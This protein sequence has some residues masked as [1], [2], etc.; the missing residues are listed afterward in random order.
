MRDALAVGL[1]QGIRDLNG[2]AQ[3]LIE[4]QRTLG[5]PLGQRF[6]LQVLHDQEV[7]T[8]LLAD[9]VEGADVRVAQRGNCPGLTLEPLF[10]IRMSGDM[11]GQ[12][13]D[14][15]G[16]VQA[17]VSGFVDFAHSSSAQWGLDFVGTESCA[18][19]FSWTLDCERVLAGGV[20]R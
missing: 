19:G 3:G 6:A 7:G 4:W 10:E 12:D 14:G 5:Q 13:F 18:L 8:V 2:V 17:G 1:V 9:V 16:A 15:N 11:L 20:S